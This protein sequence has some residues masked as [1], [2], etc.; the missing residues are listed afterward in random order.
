M[1]YPFIFYRSCP[2]HFHVR[3]TKTIISEGS[4]LKIVSHRT[5]SSTS[6][7]CGRKMDFGQLWSFIWNGYSNCQYKVNWDNVCY[8]L[9]NGYSWHH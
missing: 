3:N 1:S 2:T 7:F 4:K 6:V 9:W 8:S 5:K